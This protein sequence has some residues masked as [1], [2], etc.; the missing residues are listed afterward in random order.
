MIKVITKT[1]VS[2]FETDETVED[3]LHTSF[4]PD[5]K[6]EYYS[7]VIIQS[8]LLLERN[9]VHPQLN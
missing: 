6:E 3:E 9:G 5:F 8:H 1:E 2:N 7:D 4:H